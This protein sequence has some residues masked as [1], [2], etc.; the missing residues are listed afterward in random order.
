MNTA[1]QNALEQLKKTAEIINLDSKSLELLQTPQNIIEVEIPVVMD[2]GQE[3]IFKG[4]RAQH[5]NALGP[6]K[7]GIR[8]HPKVE[9]DEVKALAL[10]MTWKG[11][12]VGIPFGGGKGGVTVDPKELSKNELEKLAR[13]YIRAIY[14][15]IGPQKDIPAPDVN[16]TPQIMA[17]MMDEYSKIAGYNVPACITGKPVEIFGSIGR[18]TATAQ[19]GVYV[20]Q[21]LVQKKNLIPQE[22]KVV[23]QGFGN[24]GKY[25]A[26]ILSQLGYKI[27]G[28]SD[29]KGGIFC[30]NGF[31]NIDEIINHKKTTRS[32]VGFNNLE[33]ISNKELLELPA[34]ILILGAMENQITEENAN[35][36]K[37]KIILELANGPI[38]YEAD[39]IL[40]ENNI[41]IIPDILANSGGITVSYF[42]WVQNLRNFYWDEDK[43]DRRLKKI[44]TK[45]CHHV[46]NIAEEKQ[47]DM[48][49]AANILAVQKVAK[50]MELRGWK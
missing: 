32:V 21:E 31:N 45:A 13:G 50:A 19:G 47:T 34:D 35:N 8:F 25:S 2:N 28:V 49:T 16:T 20:L 1:L 30:E 39:K 38:T 44:M 9:K 15:H 37:A 23:V 5:N 41:C 26:T 14:D 24:V 11:A 48:R 46:Y 3:K 29:S 12:I 17:W 40:A 6:Y 36:I 33:T 27:I 7:G 10:W 18:N 22:I 42:E 4:Y 43:V